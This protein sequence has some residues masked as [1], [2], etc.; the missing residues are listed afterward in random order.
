M[1]PNRPDVAAARRGLA[2]PAW[3]GPAAETGQA[4][5]GLGGVSHS[6]GA[7]SLAVQG[8]GVQGEEV[9]GE[10]AAGGQPVGSRRAGE[11]DLAAKA[12][13]KRAS[14]WATPAAAC[15]ARTWLGEGGERRARWRV[16]EPSE[17]ADVENQGADVE[18]QAF[19]GLGG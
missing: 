13:R 1:S 14:L 19:S 2:R 18:N 9:Q 11:R 15:A 16:A 10:E 17:G 6:Q 3:W 8:E 7:G 12:P 5:K 4:Q